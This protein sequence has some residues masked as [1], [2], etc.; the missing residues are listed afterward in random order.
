MH[1]HNFS[2]VE[3]DIWSP[4]MVNQITLGVNYFLQTFDDVNTSANPL[5]LGL[6]TGY[7]GFGSP[8][9]KITGFDYV[10]ATASAGPHGRR[11]CTSPIISPIPRVATS[12]NSAANTAMPTSTWPIS[13]TP[14]ERLPS[15]A[16]GALGFRPRL[17]RF[18]LS[19]SRWRTSLPVSLPTPAAPLSCAEIPSASIWSIP[20]MAGQHDTFQVNS[21]LS[22]NFGVRYTYE[23]V[24]HTSGLLYN[25]LPSQGFVTTPLYDPSKLDF[26][27]RFGFAYTPIKGGK[28]V[29]RGGWGLFYDVPAV[30]EFTAAGGVGNGGANGAAYNPIGAS[31]VYT[32]SA[33]NVTFAPGVPVFGTV[34][35]TPPF[36]AFSVNPN[37]TMPHVMNFN[38]N[39]QRQLTKSTLLQA[40]LCGKRRPQAG[41]HSRYQ[42]ACRTACG[43]MPSQ[44]P[45]P[46]CH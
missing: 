38:L 29:I 5:A 12:L 27:P 25:F 21:Q 39:I 18:P 45:T 8:T 37:F 6:N 15:T 41:G 19:S 35:A 30:S 14:A 36:G 22:L 10:G 32:L 3:N 42:S 7:A 44:Y 20:S 26:A 46:G 1:V 2:V 40:G 13:A 23:G 11:R 4:R 34:A 9:I 33:T 17:A 16:A 31:P 28:W 43:P 24:P